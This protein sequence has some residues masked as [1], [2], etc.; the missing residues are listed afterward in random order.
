MFVKE[1]RAQLHNGA[2]KPHSRTRASGLR[3]GFLKNSQTTVDWKLL[4]IDS[5]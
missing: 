3:N 2:Q 4:A 1:L 5:E